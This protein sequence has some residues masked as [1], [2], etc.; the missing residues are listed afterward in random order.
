M[1]DTA[2]I[3][4]PPI[5]AGDKAIIP[6]PPVGKDDDCIPIRPKV[7]KKA[8]APPKPAARSVFAEGVAKVEK[9]A[10]TEPTVPVK[11]RIV[12]AVVKP[13]PAPAC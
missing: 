5:V 9:R 10:V 2:P 1:P 7:V 13:R 4:F 8:D 3:V 11:K 6:E 12:P